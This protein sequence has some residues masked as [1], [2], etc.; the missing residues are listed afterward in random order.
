MFYLSLLLA[1]VRRVRF[2]SNLPLLQFSQFTLPNRV[3]FVGIF[4]SFYTP[5]LSIL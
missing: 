2:V 5:Q 3:V 1:H 4:H